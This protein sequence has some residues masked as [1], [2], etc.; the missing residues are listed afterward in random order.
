MD[1]VTS[2]MNNP[3][4]FAFVILIF[5]IF[6]SCSKN[7]SG[8][9]NGPPQPCDFATNSVVTSSDVPVTYNAS[10]S[11]NA[12]ITSLIYQGAAGPV[13]VTNPKLPW[14]I[15]VAISEGDTV[16]LSAVGSASGGSLNLSYL[17]HYSNPNSNSVSCGN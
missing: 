14:T 9:N 13:T 6:P 2:K 1:P 17:I 7:D 10:N 3:G 15:T 16:H 8:N 4:L 11:N 5:V 12:S